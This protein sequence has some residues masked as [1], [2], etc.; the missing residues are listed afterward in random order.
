[1]PS[2][3]QGLALAL[4]DPLD[5]VP[6][7]GERPAENQYSLMIRLG[8]TL[9]DQGTQGMDLLRAR[10]ELEWERSRAEKAEAALVRAGEERTALMDAARAS[11]AAADKT[12]TSLRGQ[13]DQAAQND[14]RL[15]EENGEL[16]AKLEQL[17][18]ASRGYNIDLANKSAEAMCATQTILARDAEI[19]RLQKVVRLLSVPVGAVT[20]G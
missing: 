18:E 12:E 16:K 2:L 17:Q 13:L 19:I 7:A 8:R 14:S 1:M 9:R 4:V 15:Q 20:E 11:E 3:P 6:A 10:T 5:F